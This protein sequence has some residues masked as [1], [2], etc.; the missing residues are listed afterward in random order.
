MHFSKAWHWFKLIFVTSF[1]F[2]TAPATFTVITQL[3]DDGN[4]Q[5]ASSLIT[6]TQDV[7]LTSFS[8]PSLI[9]SSRKASSSSVLVSK[10]ATLTAVLMKTINNF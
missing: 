4:V 5:L 6:D 3:S 9:Q 10:S 2:C 7:E 8:S 1:H